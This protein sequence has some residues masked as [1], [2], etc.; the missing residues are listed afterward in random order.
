MFLSLAFALE[1][2]IPT[3]G[4]VHQDALE[5]CLKMWIPGPTP[6]LTL[7]MGPEFAFLA[8]I[9]GVLIRIS[10]LINTKVFMPTHRVAVIQ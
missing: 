4:H 6:D 9:L 8:T 1:A 10:S 3:Q 5:R 7:G 2:M